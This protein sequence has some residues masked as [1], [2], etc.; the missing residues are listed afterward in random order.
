MGF[1][2]SISNLDDIPEGFE[3]LGGPNFFMSLR[4]GIGGGDSS[5]HKLVFLALEVASR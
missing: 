4:R 5:L 1:I 2:N 3:G